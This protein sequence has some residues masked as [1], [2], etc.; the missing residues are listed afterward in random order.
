ML[1]NDIH[2]LI[3]HF[4]S[5]G[6]L[7]LSLSPLSGSAAAEIVPCPVSDSDAPVEEYQLKDPIAAEPNFRACQIRILTYN[8]QALPGLLLSDIDRLDDIATLLERRLRNNTAPHV[9]FIQEAFDEQSYPMIKRLQR[10][11]YPHVIRGAKA[12]GLKTSS[13]LYILSRYPFHDPAGIIYGSSSGTDSFARKG[14]LFV[15]VKIP[16]L[17]TPLEL[18]GTHM[19]ADSA[20]TEPVPPPAG[21][22][23]ADRYRNHPIFGADTP[24]GSMRTRL[25]QT[26]DIRVF[27]AQQHKLGQPAILAGDFNFR[28]HEIAY[29]NFLFFTQSKNALQYCGYRRHCSGETIDRIR[30]DYAS[31][32]DHQFFVASSKL[33]VQPVHLEKIFDQPINL[34]K[35]SRP[36]RLSDHDGLEVHYILAEPIL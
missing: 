22:S 10:A 8:I 28:P 11:G 14:M 23:P 35:P 29:V 1:T 21:T 9:I 4:T 3:S 36:R 20:N 18:Y 26:Q 32:Y 25:E 7:F 34:K 17:G 19:N 6:L 24:L 30:Y 2:R 15:K 12:K 13:G 27:W 5:V 31:S 33:K 16:G